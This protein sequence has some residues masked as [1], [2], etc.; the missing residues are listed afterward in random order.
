MFAADSEFDRSRIDLFGRGIRQIPKT[1]NA[2]F[3]AV[4]ASKP[5]SPGFAVE[6]SRH[7][8]FE[9]PVYGCE[10]PF[11]HF[12]NPHVAKFLGFGFFTDDRHFEIRA[13]QGFSNRIAEFVRFA[14][15]NERSN[16][17]MSGSS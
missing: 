13:F 12:E 17:N 15:R 3:Y 7:R 2:V 5:E 11:R 1:E 16:R 6:R 10:I 14:R 9:L 4:P 8:I